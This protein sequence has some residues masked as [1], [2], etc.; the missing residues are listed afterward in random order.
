MYSGFLEPG[1][2]AVPFV[3]ADARSWIFAGTGAHDGTAIPGVVASDVDGFDP[4][5][6]PSTV[7][8]LGHSPVP[9]AESQAHIRT[10]GA[11]YYSDM[12]YYTDPTSKAGIFASGTNTWI[13]ALTPCLPPSA[14]CPWRFAQ[15]VTGNLLHLFGQGPTGKTTPSQPNWFRIPPY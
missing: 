12:T 5:S 13:P 6:H 7:Q 11:I 9:V 1:K 10:W 15:R 4:A 2:P 14:G 8:I 3:V